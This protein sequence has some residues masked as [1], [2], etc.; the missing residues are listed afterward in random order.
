V[1]ELIHLILKVSKMYIHAPQIVY[2]AFK[3][4]VFSAEIAKSIHSHLLALWAT[5]MI[6]RFAG[7][8]VCKTA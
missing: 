2:S 8:A 7:L 5:G 3:R 6:A 1:N 4:K